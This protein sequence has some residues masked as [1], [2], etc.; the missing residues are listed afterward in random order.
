[1]P[2]GEGEQEKSFNPVAVLSREELDIQ[3]ATAK[4][5]PRS[6]VAFKRMAEEM[7]TLDEETAGS[8]FYTLPRAGKRI[9]GPSVRLAEIVGSAWGNVRY[10]GRVVEVQERY[11]IAQGTCLDLERNTGARVEVRRRIT[12]KD[13]RRYDDDMIGVTAN[14]AVSIAIR[15]CIF[16][17][18]P[19]AYI[20]GIYEKSKEV[21][22]G[23][24]L[25]MEQRR[26]RAFEWFAKIGAKQEDLFKVLERKGLEDITVDDLVALQGMKNAIM[27]GDATWESMLRDFSGVTEPPKKEGPALSKLKD[28]LK[29]DSD[30]GPPAQ[31]EPP[32]EEPEP[33]QPGDDK[34]DPVDDLLADIE[35]MSTRAGINELNRQLNKRLAQAGIKGNDILKITNALNAKKKEI[36]KIQEKEEGA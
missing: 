3:I 23:K 24:G 36:E 17:V 35:F 21:A 15:Q 14:A 26:T 5:F 7:A 18:V 19:F 30:K 1:M 13:G 27:D 11:V 31:P 9:E 33:G 12:N 28:N 25:S 29:A 10:D 20:K 32:Q 2:N 8:M 34:R 4:K 6:I 22:I 16:K